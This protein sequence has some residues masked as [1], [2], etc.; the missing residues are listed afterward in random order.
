VPAASVGA[1]RHAPADVAGDGGRH[2]ATVAFRCC[3]SGPGLLLF[4]PC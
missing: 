3:M 2:G 1:P 4:Q